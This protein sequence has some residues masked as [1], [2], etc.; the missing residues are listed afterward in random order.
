VEGL[1]A[2]PDAFETGW[3]EQQAKE[4]PVHWEGE[5]EKQRIGAWSLVQL[6]LGQTPIPPDEKPEAVEVSVEADL[7]RHG[8]PIL[9][10]ILDLVRPAGRFT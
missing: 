3:K 5:E 1:F 8:L 9:R 7:V 2:F 4:G 10:G 6:Y